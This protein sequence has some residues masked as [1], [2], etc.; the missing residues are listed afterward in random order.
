MGADLYGPEYFS[1]YMPD[2]EAR[3]K[4]VAMYQ[5]EYSRISA[6]VKGGNVLDIGCGVG[7]FLS[8]FDDK[9]WARYGIDVSTYALQLATKKDVRTKLPD[10]AT[11]YFD[12]VVFRGTLQHL[13][14]P[15][16]MIKRSIAWLKPGGYMVFLATPNI[17]SVCYR[18]FQELPMIDPRLNYVLVSPK[19]LTQILNNLGMEVLGFHFPYRS[20]PYARPLH[21]LACFVGRCFGIRRA[22]AFWG[23]VLECYARKPTNGERAG[24]L[25]V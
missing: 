20:T 22:F 10:P 11:N 17:G 8:G 23:N 14:E 15:L 1:S 4:R 18:L 5:H 12:L 7:D 21:D 2:S 13:D 16:S 19:I 3:T 9:M 25:H 24:R 6:F